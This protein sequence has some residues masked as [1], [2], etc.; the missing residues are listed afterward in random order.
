MTGVP[1]PGGG[2]GSETGR[3]HGAVLGLVEHVDDPAGQ[4]RIQVRCPELGQNFL[5]TWAPIASPMAGNDR[6][7]WMIPEVGDEAVLIFQRGDVNHPIVVGFVWN[8]QDHAPSTAVRER[9]IRS[10]NGHTIRLID[11]TA[12][13]GGNQGAIVIE[14][15]HGNQ[16]VLTNGKVSITSRGVLELAGATVIIRTAGVPRVISPTPNPI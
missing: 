9:M 16:I 1:P 14:D 10:K 7:Q 12:T 11:S 8:G 6:G 4:G 15:A 5:T 2:Y 13:G 3:I